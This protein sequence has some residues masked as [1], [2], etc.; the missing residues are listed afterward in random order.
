M[1]CSITFPAT[2]F[3]NSSTPNSKLYNGTAS[4]VSIASISATG[5]TMTAVFSTS[6]TSVTTVPTLDAWSIIGIIALSSIVMYRVRRREF[7]ND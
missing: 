4:G 7:S 2:T 1:T 3:N 5:T 6:T